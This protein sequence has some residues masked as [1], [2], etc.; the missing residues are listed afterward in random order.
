MSD[1]DKHVPPK[2]DPD[3]RFG[4]RAVH[5]GWEPD[6][7][8][9]AVMPPVYLTS[10]FVQDGPGQ[11]RGGY[12]YSRTQ[13]PTRFALQDALARTEKPLPAD[14]QLTVYKRAVD[15]STK[16]LTNKRL[17]G[18]QDIAWA[19]INTPAFLFNH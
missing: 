16:Q 5:A 1:P 13:N 3:A 8:T 2:R 14:P 7:Q 6:A 11:P 15:L 4:T 9:G 17:Y 19:L 12:E 10:T 18:A